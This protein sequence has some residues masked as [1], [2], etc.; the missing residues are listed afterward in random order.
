ML[1][2]RDASIIPPSM[3]PDYK[4]DEKTVKIKPLTNLLTWHPL[5]IDVIER[6]LSKNKV[7]EKKFLQR[8]EMAR[9]RDK[10]NLKCLLNILRLPHGPNTEFQLSSL[11]RCKTR[12]NTTL[13]SP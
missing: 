11:E 3:E 10:I 6:Y 13:E 2:I 1:E 8:V 9:S 5:P 12:S 7:L 4:R